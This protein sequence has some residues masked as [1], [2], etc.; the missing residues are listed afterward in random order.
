MKMESVQ[1]DGKSFSLKDQLF[2]E[3]KV[4]YLANLIFEV[5]SD[6]SEYDFVDCVMDKLLDLELKERM[7]WITEN[8]YN[9][10]P[11]D[12]NT[13]TNILISSLPVACD[14]EHKDDFIFGPYCEYVQ[15]YGCDEINLKQS[16]F[17][18]EK[19]SEYFSSEFAIRDFIN[20][21]PVE[22]FEFLSMM[23][24]HS[25]FMCQRLASEGLRPKLPWAK[26]INFD[27]KKGAE[28]LDNLFYNSH[29]IVVRSVAN[30][31]NDISKFDEDFVLECL[32]FW[33]KSGK[34][35]K[36]EMDYLINHSLRG[37]VKA[38]NS[39]TM[40]FLGFST[41]PRVCV[42]NFD[43]KNSNINLG[44]HVEFDFNILS[45]CDENLIVDYK[46]TYPMPSGRLSTKVFK[47]K[48]FLIGKN[49]GKVSLSKRH[50]FVSMSTKKLYAGSY[51]LEL[52]IN[53][54]SYLEREFNLNF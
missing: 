39:K 16:F 7:S 21:F 52:I 15:I 43:L 38:G 40:E 6:F 30:H 37:L 33:K 47:I 28:L 8:L 42:L 5:Y 2:N 35:E 24:M 54:V 20:R 19:T 36:V 27:Y 29:R 14:T 9:F 23:S 18:M 46:I 32:G 4:K 3:G 17:L 11:K 34:Q 50:R 48:K 41:S 13:A 1:S 22:T 44:E 25:N 10:L 31:L 49:D 53:G 45:E 26:K 12:F 51:K